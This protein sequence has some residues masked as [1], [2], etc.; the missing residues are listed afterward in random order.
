MMDR[1]LF[2]GTGSLSRFLL[3]RD[4]IRIPIWI[5]GFVFTT[6]VIGA[7]FTDL[8]ENAQER[9]QSRKQ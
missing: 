3:R 6:V 5:S 4:R 2:S 1:H 9:R 7:A 8:Y